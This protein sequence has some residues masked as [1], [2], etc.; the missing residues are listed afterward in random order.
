MENKIET[1][2]LN[3][4]ANEVCEELYSVARKDPKIMV[5]N[6]CAF[7]ILAIHREAQ[8]I[9]DTVKIPSIDECMAGLYE[10][11]ELSQNPKWKQ[12]KSWHSHHW[13]LSQIDVLEPLYSDYIYRL[14]LYLPHFVL[15]L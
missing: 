3:W 1:S 14:K 5:N 2:L 4:V 15:T 12:L 7:A 11:P 9:I 13:K 8:S 6:W 10:P